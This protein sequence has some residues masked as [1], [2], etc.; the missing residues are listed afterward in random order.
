VRREIQRVATSYE[1]AIR[2][3]ED[4]DRMDEL[5]DLLLEVMGQAEEELESSE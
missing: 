1:E 4:E 2:A 5:E 3:G